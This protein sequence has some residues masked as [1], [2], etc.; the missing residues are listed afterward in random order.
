MFQV[1]FGW[2]VSIGPVIRQHI[3]TEI[4][5]RTSQPTLRSL[6]AK[7]EK[8]TLGPQP[9]PRRHFQGPTICQKTV[10]F[11]GSSYLSLNCTKAKNMSL[12]LES[13]QAFQTQVIAVAGRFVLKVLDEKQDSREM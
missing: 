10:H 13:L 3:M 8:E 2:L 1:I 5:S 7:S 9:A 11:R 4:H 6:E 12:T